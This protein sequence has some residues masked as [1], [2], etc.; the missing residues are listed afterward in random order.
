MGQS[1]W[2]DMNKLLLTPDKTLTTNKSKGSIKVQIDEAMN[3][4][5][6]IYVSF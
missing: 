4:I 2:K 3:F 6:I 5:E 1:S